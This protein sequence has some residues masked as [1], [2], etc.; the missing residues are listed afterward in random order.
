MRTQKNDQKSNPMASVISTWLGRMGVVKTFDDDPLV[1][2]QDIVD[3]RQLFDESDKPE[4][5][6]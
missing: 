6:V 1:L 5:S 4:E 3:I 2:E